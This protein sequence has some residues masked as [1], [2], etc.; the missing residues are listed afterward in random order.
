MTVAQEERLNTFRWLST[1]PY[2]QHHENMRKG[3]L[4]NSSTWLLDHT[5]LQRWVAASYS[6][7]LWVHGS[8][9]SGKSKLM[10][11]SV[12]HHSFL[13]TKSYRS[14]VID[15]LIKQNEAGPQ[16]APIVYFYYARDVA[17]PERVDP[18]KVLLSIARQSSGT[19]VTQPIHNA[20]ISRYA[21]FGKKGLDIDASHHRKQSHW[22]WS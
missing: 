8:S 19:D 2:T 10:G 6:S 15:K 11:V 22:F 3:R 20:T 1:L 18:D 16:K 13:A 5:D 9:G 4:E 17:E 14:M 12:G 7:I 21:V